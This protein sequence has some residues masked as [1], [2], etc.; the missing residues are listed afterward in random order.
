MSHNITVESG[1]SVRLPTAGKYC[2][3]DIVITATGGAEDLYE[4]L[5]AQVEA[6]D[7]LAEE[8]EH[9]EDAEPSKLQIILGIQDINNSYTITQVDVG[10]ADEIP[11][12]FFYQKTGL[13]EV[14][15][16]SVISLGQ[17]AFY[18]CSNLEEVNLPNVERIGAYCFQ[19]CAKIK[20]FDFQK[21]TT[22]GQRAFSN[23][24]ALESISIPEVTSIGTY[25][26]NSCT[27]LV[28]VVMQKVKT[29]DSYA[30]QH[31]YRIA[32]MTI[33]AT[34]TSI[35]NNAFSN[36]GRYTETGKAIY[37]FLGDKPPT[38]Y[39]NSF[40]KDYIEKIIVNK[41][42]GETYKAATNWAGFADYIEE[43]AE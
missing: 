6:L 9:L 25:A 42:C 18:S 22:V 21:A 24:T 11:Q 28:N 36:F 16:P 26:F 38:I 12:Y 13:T 43:A 14:D 20:Y 35:G 29:I 39:A 31:C 4:E 27:Y 19:H 1:K 33:P 15:I 37:R 32:H 40:N 23:C 3:R 2:D 34:C 10:N 41:G 17:Y 7:V 30:F 5:T 8:I